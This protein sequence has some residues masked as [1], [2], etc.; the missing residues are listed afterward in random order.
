M[1]VK[2]KV[3]VHYK[4]VPKHADLPLP[5]VHVCRRSYGRQLRLPSSPL[6]VHLLPLLLPHTD[7]GLQPLVEAVEC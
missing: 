7:L 3:F 5:G 1:I 2:R 4:P 6:V